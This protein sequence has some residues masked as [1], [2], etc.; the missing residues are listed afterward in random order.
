MDAEEGAEEVKMLVKVERKGA[1]EGEVKE[2]SIRCENY[3]APTL[4]RA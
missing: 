2:L 1:R 3:F 4:A